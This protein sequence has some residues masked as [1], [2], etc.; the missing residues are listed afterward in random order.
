MPAGATDVWLVGSDGVAGEETIVRFADSTL[1]AR[2][3]QIGSQIPR[4]TMLPVRS[5]PR[6]TRTRITARRDMRPLQLTLAASVKTDY[7][8]REKNLSG[9][10]LDCQNTAFC[11]NAK[12][13]RC[14]S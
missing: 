7:S 10:D 5:A 1:A 6:K 13:R 9:T 14:N 11:C 12:P 8:F 3:F 4:I 2:F